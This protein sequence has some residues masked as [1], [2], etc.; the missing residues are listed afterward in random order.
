MYPMLEDKNACTAIY[1]LEQFF[2]YCVAGKMLTKHEANELLKKLL[3]AYFEEDVPQYAIDNDENNQSVDVE[4][5]ANILLSLIGS[6]YTK[7][8]E[9]KKGEPIN[10]LPCITTINKTKML[11]FSYS[12][13]SG[14]IINY[15]SEVLPD[16][17]ADI[18][19]LQ[20]YFDK[21]V[22]AKRSLNSF[23]ND[24]GLVKHSSKREDYSYN[25]KTYF[26][27]IDEAFLKYSQ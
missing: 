7:I 14:D 4:Q 27:L 22:D 15:L 19:Q 20:Y 16:R 1:F 24:K 18:S 17:Q 11:L 23:L 8:P 25:S 3:E 21:T 26:A 12:D 9:S 13:W 2:G 6:V 5:A 10:T